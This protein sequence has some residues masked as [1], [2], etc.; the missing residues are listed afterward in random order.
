MNPPIAIDPPV[1]GQWAIF[2]PQGHPRLAYDFLAVDDGKS[3][4]DGIN[5]LRHIVSTVSVE[6]T[7]AWN[8][9]VFVVMAATVR[10]ET[11]ANGDHLLL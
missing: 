9:P 10:R 8:R 1:R 3:P 7:F 2:N 6:S 11:L 4:Y 5:L